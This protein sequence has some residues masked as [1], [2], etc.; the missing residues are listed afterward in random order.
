MYFGQGP[1][2]TELAEKPGFWYLGE[3]AGARFD[4]GQLAVVD[5][6][7]SRMRES[8]P[9]SFASVAK[10]MTS[11]D[12]YVVSAEMQRLNASFDRA[13]K[14]VADQ[15]AE[16]PFASDATVASPVVVVAVVFHAGVAVTGV[17]VG[18]VA[19]AV[20]NSVVW[21]NQVKVTS[22]VDRPGGEER[23]LAEVTASLA[24]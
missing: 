14:V 9:H 10:R 18:V 5:S 4:A 21:H 3:V 11:G 23:F 20:A 17:A 2:A 22:R 6:I 24:A 15:H 8:D 7:V 19:V 16:D 13:V 1:L 12:P